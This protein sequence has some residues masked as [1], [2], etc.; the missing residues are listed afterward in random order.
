VREEEGPYIKLYDLRAK[1]SVSN[2]YGRMAKSVLPFLLALHSIRRPIY[3]L[4]LQEGVEAQREALREWASNLERR[5]ELQILCSTE[6][7]AIE[8][9]SAIADS[10][11]GPRPQQ[12]PMLTPLDRN[13]LSPLPE[14]PRPSVTFREKFG[15]GVTDIVGR[16]EPLILE[17]EGSTF[18]V[19]V[20]AQEGQ[21]RALRSYFRLSR[22]G[23]RAYVPA[24]HAPE[25]A[26]LCQLTTSPDRKHDTRSLFRPRD[27]VDERGGR[28]FYRHGETH[29]VRAG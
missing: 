16:L 10:T 29:R 9:A 24:S 18:P 2:I 13:L 11:G 12:R 1:T 22:P 3:L 7:R 23:G 28:P 14:T 4:L 6:S 20:V 19:L 17:L 26:L 27:D 15:E 8:E 25:R 5:N 21:C